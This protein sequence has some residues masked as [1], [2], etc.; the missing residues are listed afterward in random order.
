MPS[1][2]TSFKLNPF[3]YLNLLYVLSVLFHWHLSAAL[4]TFQI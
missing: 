3:Y 1:Q 4:G 2:F